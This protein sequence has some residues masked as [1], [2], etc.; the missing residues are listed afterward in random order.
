MENQQILQA[1]YNALKNSKEPPKIFYKSYEGEI[2]IVF[3]VKDISDP[4]E[5]KIFRAEWVV[6]ERYPTININTTVLP[7]LNQPLSRIIP[8]GFKRFT[9]QA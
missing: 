3:V 6:S 9:A 7:K 8:E 2:K 4:M 5:E 1:F